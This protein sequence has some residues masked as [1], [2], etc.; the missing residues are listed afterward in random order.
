MTTTPHGDEGAQDTTRMTMTHTQHTTMHCEQRHDW[1][2]AS[3]TKGG[4]TPLQRK[5]WHHHNEVKDAS[6]MLAATR[7][8]RGQ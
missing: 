1:A 3:A 6:A 7:M 2:D 5:H 8:Q 4:A